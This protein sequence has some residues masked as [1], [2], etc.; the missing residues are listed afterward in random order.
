MIRKLI[1]GLALVGV[2]AVGGASVVSAETSG[3]SGT[4]PSSTGPSAQS[5]QKPV[6]DRVCARANR[7]VSFLQ[8]WQTQLDNRIAKLQEK[9]TQLAQ[10]DPDK[11]AKVA[12][13]ITKLQKRSSE[14]KEYTDKIAGAIGEK[15]P[16][17]TPAPASS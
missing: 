2:L 4:G 15:C 6:H 8:K 14:L 16:A 7:L 1:A 10:T 11:A 17:P 5:D 9:Q 3:P 13:L 12:D